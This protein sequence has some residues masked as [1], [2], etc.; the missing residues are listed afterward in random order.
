MRDGTPVV[1]AKLLLAKERMAQE[2]GEGDES[3]GFE[4]K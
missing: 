1:E 3:P 2:Y 4:P